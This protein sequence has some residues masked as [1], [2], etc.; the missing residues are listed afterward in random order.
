MRGDEPAASA[1]RCPLHSTLAGADGG[2]GT[3]AWCFAPSLAYLSVAYQC[4][5]HWYTTGAAVL[6]NVVLGDLTLILGVCDFLRPDKWLIRRVLAPKASTQLEMNRLYSLEGQVD[7]YLPFRCACT[8][9]W[10]TT[11]GTRE[12]MRVHSPAEGWLKAG[13]PKIIRPNPASQSPA[14]TA[15]L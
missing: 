12:H 8:C 2:G 9:G 10:D 14:V 13:L 7:F 15:S 1:T 6:M 4:V 3:E 5:H 11:G